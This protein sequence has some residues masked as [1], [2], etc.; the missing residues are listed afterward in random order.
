MDVHYE[1]DS[2][3]GFL[4][5]FD[6][7]VFGPYESVGIVYDVTDGII[8]LL[9]HGGYHRTKA[10]YEKAKASMTAGSNPEMAA[11]LRL[12]EVCHCDLKDLN[13][14]VNSAALPEKW[15]ERLQPLEAQQ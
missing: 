3:G 7:D 6:D 5:V 4:L 13:H 2:T 14:F 15:I 11:D 9:K 10:W 8:C 12:V 1:H